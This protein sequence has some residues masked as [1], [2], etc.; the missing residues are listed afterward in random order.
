MFLFIDFSFWLANNTQKAFSSGLDFVIWCC[1]KKNKHPN[2]WHQSSSIDAMHLYWC[3]NEKT[4]H[5]I[6]FVLSKIT[7]ILTYSAQSSLAKLGR[8]SEQKQTQV[9][10]LPVFSVRNYF[11][12][13]QG[14]GDDSK[15]VWKKFV[16]DW[17]IVTPNFQT[18]PK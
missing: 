4:F 3:T 11:L 12:I 2:T 16:K 15:V 13:H 7:C 5:I 18:K 10:C 6:F 14:C 1:N 8:C 9:I 17:K